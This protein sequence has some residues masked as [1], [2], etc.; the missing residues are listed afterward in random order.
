MTLYII[1]NSHSGNRSAKDII[2]TLKTH[3]E[4]NVITF[5]RDIEMMKKIK[6][7]KFKIFQCSQDKLLI[8]GGDG[9]LSKVLYY[10]PAE[11]PFAYYP[12]GS[13][14]DFARALGLRKIQ[15]S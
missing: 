3:S 12:I 10:W 2:A 6:L 11:I 7:S 14:N 4:Q 15:F 8:L 1:A 9:T 5:L 13:G